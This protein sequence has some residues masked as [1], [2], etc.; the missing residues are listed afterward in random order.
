MGLISTAECAKRKGVSQ[1]AVSGA[2][3]RGDI[4]A[5]TIG[6]TYAMEESACDA[7]EPDRGQA[8]RAKKRWEKSESEKS[9]E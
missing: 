1:A 3:K 2:I 7:W 9:D 6:R 5:Q 4:P 8:A